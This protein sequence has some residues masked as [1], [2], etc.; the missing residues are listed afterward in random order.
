M[1]TIINFFGSVSKYGKYVALVVVVA[2]FAIS[3][4]KKLEAGGS[5]SQGDLQP[6]N[7]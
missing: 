1:D 5:V 4:I 3:E 2:E 6:S 7:N